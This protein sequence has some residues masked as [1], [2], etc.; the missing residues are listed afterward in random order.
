[1]EVTL[2][3]YLEEIDRWKQPV[4]DRTLAV[5]PPMR[6]SAAYEARA[7]LEAKLGKRLDEAPHSGQKKALSA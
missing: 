7:W 3:E 4:T 2:D 1:M 5:P 6:A